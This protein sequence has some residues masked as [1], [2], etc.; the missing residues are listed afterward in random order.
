MA[1]HAPRTLT[2]CSFGA[3]APSESVR[4]PER[5]EVVHHWHA[6]PAWTSHRLSAASRS[7]SGSSLSPQALPLTGTQV[8]QPLAQTRKV[9]QSSLA[10]SSWQHLCK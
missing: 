10:S 4:A 7:L 8:T 2:M 1:R 3:T 5:I 6:L 9:S